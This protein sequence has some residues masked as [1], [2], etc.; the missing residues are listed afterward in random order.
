MV[1]PLAR[2]RVLGLS[3]KEICRLSLSAVTT[4]MLV[5]L[6]TKGRVGPAPKTNP[7]LRQ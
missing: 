2:T 3:L 5:R 7:R 4:V 6:I 1:S